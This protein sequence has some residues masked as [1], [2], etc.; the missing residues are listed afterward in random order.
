M[1]GTLKMDGNLHFDIERPSTLTRYYFQDL[2]MNQHLRIST[3]IEIEHSE[4]S[5]RTYSSGTSWLRTWLIN[6]THRY[7]AW[8]VLGSTKSWWLR[9]FLRPP[10]KIQFSNVNIQLKIKN[11]K[12]W[13][14]LGFGKPI[15]IQWINEIDSMKHTKMNKLLIFVKFSCFYIVS[16]TANHAV[17]GKTIWQ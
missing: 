4:Y 8:R 14:G 2:K 1:L 10:F 6:M 16:C 13:F 17:L 15:Y 9:L 3:R 12:L 11:S 7:S 5:S